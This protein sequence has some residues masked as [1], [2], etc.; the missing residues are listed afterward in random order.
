MAR[1]LR[2][3]TIQSLPK[4]FFDDDKQL[5]VDSDGDALTWIDIVLEGYRAGAG[6]EEAI[7]DLKITEEVFQNLIKD[8]DLF[9][10]V[11]EHGRLCRYAWYMEVG[12]TN[13]TTRGFNT[14][15]WAFQM[16]NLFG[17]VDKKE[18]TINGRSLEDLTKQQIDALFT[19]RTEVLK[20]KLALVN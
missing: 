4:E 2:L 7:R 19:E 12:R 10:G 17:W 16:K 6:D 15:L 1:K 13:L 8:D 9:N 18:Q 20:K 5:R 3:P 14:T 11:V